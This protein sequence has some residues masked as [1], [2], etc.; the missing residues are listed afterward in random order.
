MTDLDFRQ[1]ATTPDPAPGAARRPGGRRDAVRRRAAR[2]LRRQQRLEQRRWWRRRR[3]PSPARRPPARS[4]GRRLKVGRRAA[5]PTPRTPVADPRTSC[6]AGTSTSRWHAR[7]G[8]VEMMVAE[9]VRP[10]TESSWVNKIGPHRVPQRQER[11]RRRRH[12]QPEPD[13]RPQGPQGRRG[14]YRIHRR[15]GPQEDLELPGPDPAEVRER[16]VPRRPRP[17]L[18]R[19]RPDQLRPQEPGR[20]RRVHVREFLARPAERV[21]EVPQLLAERPALRGPAHN[22]R[23]HR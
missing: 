21:Q 8:P 19:D 2:R 1:C 12:L 13:P 6:S 18:Q 16:R 9:S 22:H 20:H 23:L 10:S 17:V 4:S 14:L 7:T 11:H 15:Q 3:R 5:A